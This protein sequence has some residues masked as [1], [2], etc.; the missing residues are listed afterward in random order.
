MNKEWILIEV[1]NFDGDAKLTLTDDM[2]E[3]GAMVELGGEPIGRELAVSV[4]T[5]MMD[6]CEFSQRDD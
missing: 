1:G 5:A 4:F 6:G 2:I 3:A